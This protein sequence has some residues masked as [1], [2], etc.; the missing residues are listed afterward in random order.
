[1]Q[2]VSA[3]L[4]ALC[5]FGMTLRNPLVGLCFFSALVPFDIIVMDKTPITVHSNE[6]LITGLLAGILATAIRAGGRMNPQVLKILKIFMFVLVAVGL[7]VWAA[8]DRWAVFKQALR[9]GQFWLLLA[10]VVHVVRDQ[11]D[12]GRVLVWYVGAAAVVSVMGIVEVILGP[13][14]WINHGPHIV[15]PTIVGENSTIVRAHGPLSP[16]ALPSYLGFALLALIAMFHIRMD[17]TKRLMCWGLVVLL[18]NAILLTQSR[19]GWIAVA[20]G[21]VGC[22][23]AAKR[24]T[25]KRYVPI[26]LGLL[27]IIMTN[28]R[29]A[30]MFQGRV[31]SLIAPWSQGTFQSR[32]KVFKS[33]MKMWGTHPLTGIGAGNY[34]VK[35]EEMRHEIPQEVYLASRAHVHNFF[36]QLGLETGFVGLTVWL[37]GLAWIGWRFWKMRSGDLNYAELGLGLLIIFFLN[38]QFEHTLIHSR[39]VFYAIGFGVVLGASGKRVRARGAH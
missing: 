23:V 12:A 26:A 34:L 13:E 4:L 39:G 21:I 30:P 16:N 5:M 24:V 7:S 37:V 38:N 18:E 14:A 17:W 27:T 8:Q 31:E 6:A 9:W 33:G 32:M 25:L 3:L 20:I 19:T 35:L 10:A 11:R 1:M 15:P 28:V 36:L 22:V 2:F 29:W